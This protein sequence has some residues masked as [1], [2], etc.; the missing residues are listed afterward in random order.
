M[1]KL[2]DKIFQIGFILAVAAI[3]V[4]GVVMT[5][6]KYR[7]RQGLEKRRAH[8]ERRIAETQREIAA[9]KDKQRRFNTDRE[10]VESLARESRRVFPGEIVFIFKD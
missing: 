8:L 7:Q 9:L 6:P 3:V 10:F 1:G 5:F 2:V 4:G